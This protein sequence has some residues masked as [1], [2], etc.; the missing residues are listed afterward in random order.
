MPVMYA[1]AAGGM[2]APPPPI[3]AGQVDMN[4]SVNVLFELA[5]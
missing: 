1:R 5:P 2:E 3:A 4:A